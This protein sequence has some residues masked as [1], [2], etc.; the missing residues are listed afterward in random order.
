VPLP[1][2]QTIRPYAPEESIADEL[3]R[4]DVDRRFRSAAER[5]LKDPLFGV[6]PPIGAGRMCDRTR[7]VPD[8][9]RSATDALEER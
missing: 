5:P 8:E 9:R 4:H 2:A 3:V 7:E 6:G 1:T